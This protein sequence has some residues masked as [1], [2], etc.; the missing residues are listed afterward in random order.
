MNMIRYLSLVLLSS[1]FTVQ[2]HN[3]DG[4]PSVDVA[5]AQGVHAEEPLIDGR[6]LPLEGGSNFRDMG[7]Y[8]T[9]D[10]RVVRRG[11][12]FR[13]GAMTSLTTEDRQYLDRLDFKMV[14]DLRGRDER[15][16]FPNHWAEDTDLDY[17][18]HDYGREEMTRS[19]ASRT[20]FD[21]VD[22]DELMPLVYRAMPDFLAQQLADLF[23][24]LISEQ[25]PLVVN[26]SAGQDRTGLATALILHALGVPRDT[27]VEDYLLSTQYRNTGAELGDVDLSAAT[28]SNEFAR[29]M[30][31]HGEAHGQPK[32]LVNRDGRPYL[33]FAL[34]E[35]TRRYG[36]VNGYL[37]EVL[38]VDAV[39]M[40]KLRTLYLE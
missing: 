13:S 16:L 14:Y 39:R 17:R 27:I 33:L 35:I 29:M 1:T 38:G 24:V 25:T 10:G 31:R 32:P 8:E 20:L 26:C 37:D 40:E 18:Y 36:D 19:G 3:L 4:V 12:L 21:E 7:G 11:V 5:D 28:E 15:E 23:D 30:L 34:D 22:S 9:A 2:A 6:V